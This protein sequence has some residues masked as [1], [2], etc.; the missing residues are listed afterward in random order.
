MSKHVRP[1]QKLRLEWRKAL[2]S[3]SIS[4]EI[5]ALRKLSL[6]PYITIES[7]IQTAVEMLP[8]SPMLFLRLLSA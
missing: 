2:G 5:G 1:D 8:L 7:A 4:V 6:R 3:P